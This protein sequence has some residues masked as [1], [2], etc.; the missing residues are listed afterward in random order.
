[1]GVAECI[2]AAQPVKAS[3]S[4]AVVQGAERH[5][6]R[7]IARPLP[8]AFVVDLSRPATDK[9]S[10]CRHPVHMTGL[11]GETGLDPPLCYGIAHDLKWNRIVKIVGRRIAK[12]LPVAFLIFQDLRLHRFLQ[13]RA[14][15]LE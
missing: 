13:P 5:D 2:G 14:Q 7:I 6:I 12:R 1:M 9:A 3:P 10:H 8:G 15:L 4:V 11:F